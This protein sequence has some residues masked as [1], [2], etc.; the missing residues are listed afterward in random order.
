MEELIDAL[1][2]RGELTAAAAV[3]AFA[4]LGLW[5]KSRLGSSATDEAAE[6]REKRDEKIDHIGQ[7]VDK[8]DARLA[9]VESDIEHLPTRE[10]FHKVQLAMAT[11][12]QRIVGIERTT[13]ATG[14]AVGRIEDFMISMKGK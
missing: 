10:E 4:T 13:E 14:R 6:A 11:M 2:A 12:Q 7:R 1:T 9:R 5:A 8:F 3:A